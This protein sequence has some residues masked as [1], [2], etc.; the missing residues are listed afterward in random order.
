MGWRRRAAAAVVLLVAVIA[1]ALAT[2][3]QTVV[4]P[5]GQF[6]LI[7][8]ASAADVSAVGEDTA[9]AVGLKA[10]EDLNPAVRGLSFEAAHL[11]TGLRSVKGDRGHMIFSA[12]EP[13]DAWVVEF[14]APAQNGF[15]TVHGL[16]VVDART[17][18]ISSAQL[19]QSN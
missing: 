17:G 6:S 15:A 8:S 19:V 14:A 2:E 9:V 16:V 4:V 7:E 18:A 5:F 1:I 12:T 10:L 11:S 3:G 13:F